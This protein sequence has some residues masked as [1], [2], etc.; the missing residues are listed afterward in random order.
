VRWTRCFGYLLKKTVFDR[1][2]SWKVLLCGFSNCKLVAWYNE[3]LKS[4]LTPVSQ[5]ESGNSGNHLNIVC[6]IVATQ[7][8][9]QP[10]NC[11]K[12]CLSQ[13]VVDMKCGTCSTDY[14]CAYTLCRESLQFCMFTIYNDAF[15]CCINESRRYICSMNAAVSKLSVVLCKCGACII[16]EYALYYVTSRYQCVILPF[17]TLHYVIMLV[18]N[19]EILTA[20]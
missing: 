3:L 18:R 20:Y 17:E 16:C 12:L 9:S 15:V 4:G 11:S 6:S 5:R 19:I 13:N 2:M 7:P 10:A 14:K 8:T 1:L